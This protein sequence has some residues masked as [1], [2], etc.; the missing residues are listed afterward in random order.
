MM[1]KTRKMFGTASGFT[2][3]EMI[4]VLVIMGFMVAMIAP[5]FSTVGQEAVDTVCDTN[6]R[7]VRFALGRYQMRHYDGLPNNVISLIN[8]IAGGYEIPAKEEDA[9]G[10]EPQSLADEFVTRNTPMLHILD[11][12]E[13]DELAGYGID[14]M[15]IWN[16]GNDANTLGSAT[17][18]EKTDII[19]GKPVAMVGAGCTTLAGHWKL[20]DAFSSHDINAPKEHGNP[21]WLYRIMFGLGPDNSLVEENLLEG[22]ALC[23]GGIQNAAAVDYNYYVMIVPR[24]AATVARL[25]ALA[26]GSA[27]TEDC[28]KIIQIRGIGEGK[29]AATATGQRKDVTVNVA[30]DPW[31][32]DATCPEGHKWPE[33]EGSYAVH[34]TSYY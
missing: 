13:V 3:L 28:P 34:A 30:Q 32:Y 18:M 17:P 26:T 21:Y 12:G 33:S 19:A 25:E 24:L 8:Q 16:N 4:V 31:A 9:V 27:G 7:G 23:P 20:N 11:Q 15:L 1:K 6:N 10:D 5:R 2:L 22:A 29:T 14:T